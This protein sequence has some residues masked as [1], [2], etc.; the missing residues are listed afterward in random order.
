VGTR[1]IALEPGVHVDLREAIS[2][3]QVLID[4][5]CAVTEE[6]LTTASSLLRDDL[7]PGW[8]DD[9]AVQSFE[10]WRQLRLHG[11]EA[12]AQRLI[13]AGR[14]AAA[15]DAALLC[16]EADPLR[17]TAHAEVIK[18][19]LAEHNQSEAIRAFEVCCSMLRSELGLEPS[20]QLRSLVGPLAQ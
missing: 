5:R 4:K 12:L 18:I 3:A 14:F 8:Y 2:L 11:L 7:L 10:R 1:S 17:E 19:H 16:V 9:W 15:L 20:E 6:Q 13:V